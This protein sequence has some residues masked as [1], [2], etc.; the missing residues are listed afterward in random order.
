MTN[1]KSIRSL[2]QAYDN[3]LLTKFRLCHELWLIEQRYRLLTPYW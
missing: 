3:G 1:L 2:L